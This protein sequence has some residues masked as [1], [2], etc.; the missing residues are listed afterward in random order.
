VTATLRAAVGSNSGNA[1]NVTSLTVGAP[2]GMAAGDLAL[3]FMANAAAGGVFSAPAGWTSLPMYST[4]APYQRLFCKS[5]TAADVSAGSW[6]FTSSNAKALA[7][8][9]YCAYNADTVNVF[10]P[11]PPVASSYNS[12]SSNTPTANAVTATS[13]GCLAVW[14]AAAASTSPGVAPGTL[15]QPSGFALQGGTLA[16]GTTTNTTGTGDVDNVSVLVA[17]QTLTGATL[18]PANLAGTLS[19]SARPCGALLVL[20][21][22]QLDPV[23]VW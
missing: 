18:A 5:A 21:P 23:A 19:G 1:G 3:V 8:Q 11:A 4:A 16:S 6:V 15:A 12:G 2:T 17:D 13:Q 14:F 7:A 10:D 9:C 20:I 22:W